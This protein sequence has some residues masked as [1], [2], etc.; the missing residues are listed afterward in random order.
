[1]DFSIATLKLEERLPLEL[2]ALYERYGYRKYRMSQFEEY[3]LYL[4]NKR[5][6][7]S[8]K[9]ITFH[10]S[11]GRLLALKPDVTLSIVKTRAAVAR[12]R[13]SCIISKMCSAMRPRPKNTK[14]SRR[15]GWN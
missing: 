11:A 5:F 12:R 15:W 6:L 8:E 4:E 9:L 1:M 14:K 2:R 3:G 7:E 10:D 13:R